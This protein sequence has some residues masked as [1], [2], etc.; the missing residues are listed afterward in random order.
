MA[1]M[2]LQRPARLELTLLGALALAAFAAPLW[3]IWLGALAGA[4]TIAASR[5]PNAA[6]NRKPH[7]TRGLQPAVTRASTPIPSHRARP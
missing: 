7:R 4:A 3:S 1:A 5:M 6:G 2:P